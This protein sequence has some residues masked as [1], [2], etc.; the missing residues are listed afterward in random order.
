MVRHLSEDVVRQLRLRAQHLTSPGPLTDAAQVV[1][2][3]CGIQ[4]QD[5]SAVALA[6]RARSSGITAAAVEQARVR[7]RSIIRTWAMRGTLHLLA[8]EDL[9][10]L[11]SLLGPAFTKPNR[12]RHAELGLDEEL[13]ARGVAVIRHALGSGP[14]L[15][16][17]IA[18]RLAAQGIPAK[19]QA[20]V[21]LIQRA[22]LLGEIC[23]GPDRDGKPTY[24]LLND[25]I[26]RGPAMPR[27]SALAELAQRY[28]AAHGPATLADMASWTGLPMRD[29]RVGWQAIAGQ[30]VEITVA[31]QPAWILKAHASWLDGAPPNG[32]IVRLVPS[33]DP[34]LLGY[35]NRDLAVAPAHAKRIHPGGGLIHPALLGDGRAVGTWRIKRHKD[36]CELEL[37]AFEALGDEFAAGV[38]AEAADVGRFLEIPITTSLPPFSH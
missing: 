26:R 22:A 15:R 37:E 3:L 5:A 2:R 24:V 23:H 30:V 27:D 19:G 20:T 29:V 11:L 28:L 17:E 18:D 16:A 14:L 1:H 32:P 31:G 35:R 21:H 25:W 9:D 6:I 38:Q 10:W 7:N 12:A 8:T 34:Y 33:F 4:A 36:H 13:F